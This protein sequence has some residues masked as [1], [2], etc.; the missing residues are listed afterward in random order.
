MSILTHVCL[1]VSLAV[2]G[3]GLVVVAAIVDERRIA[4]LGFAVGL[5]AHAAYLDC[6]ARWCAAAVQEPVSLRSVS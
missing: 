3:V 6:R 2:I 5:I 1:A 4:W